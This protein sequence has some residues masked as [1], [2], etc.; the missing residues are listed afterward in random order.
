MADTI[1]CTR[2]KQANPRRKKDLRCQS[3]GEV[4]EDLASSCS[5]DELSDHT[6][7]SPSP[8]SHSNYH[9]NSDGIESDTGDQSFSE[10]EQDIRVERVER[11]SPL[12]KLGKDPDSRVN[13]EEYLNRSDTAVIYP[14]PVDDIDND[15]NGGTDCEDGKPV[16]CPYCDRSYKRITSLKEHIKYRHEKTISN[17]SCPECN[18]CFAYKSQ[19]ER[20]MATH[21]PGRNQV[22]DICNKAFVNIYRLQRHML[23]HSTGNRKFKCGECGKAFKYKHHL[24]EHLRIHSGEKPYECPICRKRFSHSGSYSSHIS[25]KKCSPLK[26]N[27]VMVSHMPAPVKVMNGSLSPIPQQPMTNK[28][29]TVDEDPEPAPTDKMPSYMTQLHIKIPGSDSMKDV[30]KSDDSSTDQQTTPPNDAVKKVLQIVDATVSKL[31]LQG[32]NTDISKL[33]KVSK[34]SNAPASAPTQVHSPISA[35]LSAPLPT[36]AAPIV[37]PTA[38]LPS[39]PAP[40]SPTQQPQPILSPTPSTSSSQSSPMLPTPEKVVLPEI[41]K[42]RLTSSNPVLLP[43]N[44]AKPNKIYSI[45]DYT[46]RK[47]H[48]AQAIAKCLESQR[49]YGCIPYLD[50]KGTGCKYCGREFESPIELHQ[51]E[52]YLCELNEDVQ[53]VKGYN[54]SNLTKY[55]EYQ[56]EVLA[57]MDRAR[58]RRP[59]TDSEMNDTIS[60]NMSETESLAS[61]LTSV[62]SPKECNGNLLSR[63][64]ENDN[65]KTSEIYHNGLNQISEAQ[66]HALRAFYAM[67][68][69]PSEDGLEKI[70]LA[71][72]LKPSFVE[73]WFKRTRKLEEEGCDPS[74]KSLGL[75]KKNC[76]NNNLLRTQ[77]PGKQINGYTEVSETASNDSRSRVATP[78]RRYSPRAASSPRSTS[79]VESHPYDRL[80][81]LELSRR[82]NGLKNLSLRDREEHSNCNSPATVSSRPSPRQTVD[83]APLDLSLPKHTSRNLPLSSMSPK[84]VYGYNYPPLYTTAGSYIFQSYNPDGSRAN[85][86]LEN[87]LKAH[88]HCPNG[89]LVLKRPY[90]EPYFAYVPMPN[91]YPPKR[92]KYPEGMEFVNGA[93]YPTSPLTEVYASAMM[94]GTYPPI[95]PLQVETTQP[96]TYRHNIVGSNGMHNNGISDLAM[97]VE[98]SL[99]ELSPNRD[100][101]RRDRPLRTSAGLYSCTQCPKT[102]QKHSSLL[103]HVYEHSGEPKS[104]RPHECKECGKAFKHKHHLMEHTRLHSGE[105]PYQCDKCLKKFSHSGSYSQHMNHRYSYCRKEDTLGRGMGKGTPEEE[106]EDMMMETGEIDRCDKQNGMRYKEDVIPASPLD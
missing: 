17:F 23:T 33:T 53:K 52:R 60:N 74:L 5:P 19:L 27:P 73:T 51:H 3:T 87:T 64:Q 48:E 11:R 40:P 41:S 106:E 81:Q 96:P 29:T 12:G 25:S 47:V 75:M 20:H 72:N 99:G 10:D 59:S 101:R 89:N 45:V 35:P 13:L 84:L 68:A 42:E 104:K 82:Q 91:R 88:S 21:M 30:E 93:S 69:R 24:K 67:H 2:R 65:S 8:L 50:N 78:E 92:M 70:S 58:E 71:M 46:L 38:P 9:G 37:T 94:K 103:R 56:R 6:D 34:A 49:G 61:P 39:P 80:E 14:E 57:S 31:K 36:Q 18:Y 54:N 16:D 62:H 90:A 4:D 102:F 63:S 44:G 86:C 32:Q 28:I 7:E 95:T 85:L 26:E 79:T 83:E 100:R 76:I 15:S 43:V 97:A 66:E 22:C 105:K 77:S 55:Y 1:R 98:D